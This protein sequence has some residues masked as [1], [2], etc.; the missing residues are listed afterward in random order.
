MTI[1]LLTFDL[2]DTLWPVGP[3]I[4][5]AEH[6]MRDHLDRLV[7][8]LNRRFDRE[9]MAAL[10]EQL[11]A[12]DPSLVHDISGLRRRV[13]ARAAEACG[14]AD[15]DAVAES[16][17]AEFMDARHDIEYFEDALDTLAY[18]SRHYT[19]G[20][21]S[22][23]NASVARLGLDRYFAFHLNAERVGRRKP[24]PAMFERALQEAGVGADAAVHVG[25]HP[26]DDVRGAARVGMGTVWVNRGQL[27]WE[28]AD[29]TPTWTVTELTELSALFQ[30]SAGD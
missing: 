8:A 20:A 25:D 10:R 19:L 6:R 16:A 15:P 14:H 4:V 7:P 5:R 23:G 12:E 1:R 24:D 11:L 22:N 3:V 18:L 17:F 30:D 29:V 27:P 21:L 2:D 9:G 13:I 26:H 28:E